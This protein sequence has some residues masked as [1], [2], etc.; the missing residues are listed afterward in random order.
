MTPSETYFS[1]TLGEVSEK[2]LAAALYGVVFTAQPNQ[3]RPLTV[4]LQQS[5]GKL[6]RLTA[7]ANSKGWKKTVRG[8]NASIE[9]KLVLDAATGELSEGTIPLTKLVRTQGRALRILNTIQP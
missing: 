5:N 6:D 4:T 8:K 9:C 3:T 1:L 2:D 7:F